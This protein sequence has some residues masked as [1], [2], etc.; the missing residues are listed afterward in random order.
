MT[1]HISYKTAKALKEFL[2]DKAPGPMGGS[3]YRESGVLS[4]MYSVH[5]EIYPAY[6]LHDILSKQF[7]EAMD[8]KCRH[9]YE[10]LGT[11]LFELNYAHG[12]PAV[13]AE[14][15]RMMDKDKA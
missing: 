4:P 3:W 8:A 13:E 6:Q 9:G 11:M 12:L 14:L 10:D 5:I 2:V 15:M 7:C 1:T